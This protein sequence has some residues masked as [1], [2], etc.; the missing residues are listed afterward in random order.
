MIR[1]AWATN[2]LLAAYHD[3]EWGK[4]LHDDR[5]LFELL[6]LEGAQAGLSWQTILAKREGY[7]QAFAGFDYDK[8]ARFGAAKQAVLLAN[9][10][11]VRNRAKIASAVG[12]ARA[13]LAVREEW[14]TFDAYLWRFVD[15]KPVF[16][17]PANR[18]DVPASTPLS[19][20]ISVDLKSR[21]FS[22]VGTTI[23]YA[24]LQAAGVVDD[25]LAACAFGLSK[26]RR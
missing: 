19:D 18:A 2:D 15:G 21:G 17:R 5:R 26:V 1:C 22:F 12:N 6:V 3:Q 8:V 9:P 10:G 13:F 24:F 20:A 16:R 23:V 25:H 11:I 7:R 4:P 14:G